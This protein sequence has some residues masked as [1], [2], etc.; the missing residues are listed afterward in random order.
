VSAPEEECTC[1]RASG[2]LCAYCHAW[3]RD[4]LDR[5]V[6]GGHADSAAVLARAWAEHV[7]E[8]RAS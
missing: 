3:H 5:A 6:S 4:A 8:R 2:D 7:A 1:D